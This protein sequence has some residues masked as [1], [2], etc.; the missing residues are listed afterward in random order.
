[1]LSAGGVKELGE[2]F[3][4][5]D[6]AKSNDNHNIKLP[7]DQSIALAAALRVPHHGLG[8]SR[9]YYMAFHST[10]VTYRGIGR[11]VLL[12]ISRLCELDAEAQA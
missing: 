7:A 10:R 3:G 4:F 11:S 1:M 6:E 2:Y 5:K 12:Q 8:S 9:V